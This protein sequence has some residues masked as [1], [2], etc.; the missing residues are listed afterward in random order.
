MTPH[1]TAAQGEIAKIVLLPGDPDR[2][3]WVADGFLSDAREITHKRGMR[4]FTGFY[5]DTRVSVMAS[6]MGAPSAGIYAHELF[7]HYQ[8]EAIIRIGTS[9]GLDPSIAVGDVVLAMTASTDSAWA[10]QY[11][12]PGTLSPVA[13]FALFDSAVRIARKIGTTF[14]AGMVFSSDYF[15]SYNA[16]GGESWRKWAAMGALVQD[17]ETY[18][19]YCSAAHHQKSALSLLTMTDSC[20][21]GEGLPEERRL[22]ALEPMVRLALGIAREREHDA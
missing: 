12:L 2:A 5:H 14:H 20:V 1:N 19:L 13:D 8:A 4:G 16:L 3:A 21:T 6:G 18:A 17:M 11:G 22:S 10:R 15:S 9:G 7:A